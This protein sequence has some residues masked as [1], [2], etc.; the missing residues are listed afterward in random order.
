[1]HKVTFGRLYRYHRS[2]D[3]SPWKSFWEA[4]RAMALLMSILIVLGVTA[5]VAAVIAGMII[6]LSRDSALDMYHVE[7]STSEWSVE[8]TYIAKSPEEALDQ[9]W[10][11]HV[12]YRPSISVCKVYDTHSPDRKLLAQREAPH[13]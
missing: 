2:L 12:D 1:M 10:R 7:C 4:L 6:Y 8:H 9:A 5:A 11:A 3:W 13:D